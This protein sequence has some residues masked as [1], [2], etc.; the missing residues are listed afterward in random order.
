[1]MAR[2][3][4][5]ASAPAAVWATLLDEGRYLASERTMYR[6]LAAQHGVRERRA[7]LEHPPYAAPELLAERPTRSGHGTSASSRAQRRGWRSTPRR[8]HRRHARAPT[9]TPIPTTR[10]VEQTVL[11]ITVRIKPAVNCSV[12]RRSNDLLL[13]RMRRA[14]VAPPGPLRCLPRVRGSNEL[15]LEPGKLRRRRAARSGDGR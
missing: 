12:H 1:M 13:P 8:H 14:L 3:G 15:Q 10:I 4:F 11:L 5:V 7:Q 2:P 6:L 9:P